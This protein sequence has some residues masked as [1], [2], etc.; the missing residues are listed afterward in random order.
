MRDQLPFTRATLLEI[1]RSAAAQ[2]CIVPSLL[3]GLRI[4]PRLGCCTRQAGGS[5]RAFQ[6]MIRFQRNE[7]L[8]R[9]SPAPSL[10]REC[11]RV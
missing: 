8:Q 6:M 9:Y 4:S 2:C 11:G 1:H 5:D 3:A 7:K 10:R